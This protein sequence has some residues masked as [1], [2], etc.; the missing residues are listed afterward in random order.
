MARTLQH[1]VVVV[2]GASSGIGR[3]TA[4]ALADRGATV[5]LT[6]R[7]QAALDDVVAECERAGGRALARAADVNDAAAL[8]KI[9]AEAVSAFGRLDAWVNNAGVNLYGRFEELP[10]D[11]WHQV[12]KTNLFGT[13]HGARAAIP[14]F[15][16]QGRGVLVN[17]SS[18]L[19]KVASPYQSA[20]VASKFAVRG[21]SESLRQ[22]L[23]DVPDVHVVTVLPG[24]IDTPLFQHAGNHMRRA[25]KAPRP[26][27]AV[28]R[29][30]QA[31]VAAISRPR[32][33]VVVGG[34]TRF[35]LLGNRLAPGATERSAAKQMAG[36]QFADDPELPTVGNVFEPLPEG[37]DASGGWKQPSRGRRR[38]L[39][40]AVAITAGAAAL[41]AL[42][43]SRSRD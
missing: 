22:E 3:A 9:A 31:I 19:G 27:I 6:A 38:R 41:G 36:E 28:D 42:V 5:V 10:L 23:H 24:A 37:T 21:L 8:E 35:G 2:T 17:V 39:P 1:A 40:L 7:R 12:V 32:R 34:S 26:T 11:Q 33:E 14:W 18:V 29:A 20:Y 15:R 16:Q 30:A 25:V 13:A 4:V 43:R